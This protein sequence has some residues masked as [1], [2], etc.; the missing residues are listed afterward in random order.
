LAFEILAR[1]TPSSLDLR[2]LLRETHSYNT[3]RNA[4][5]AI[6]D[7]NKSPTNNVAKVYIKLPRVIKEIKSYNTFVKTLKKFLVDKCYYNV[8]DYHAEIWQS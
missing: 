5:I 8:N 3:R 4:D 7:N 6:V 1:S 2:P